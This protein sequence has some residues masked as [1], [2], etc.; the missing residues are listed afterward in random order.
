MALFAGRTNELEA[1]GIGVSE[2]AS[3]YQESA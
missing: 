1:V 3:S 2:M